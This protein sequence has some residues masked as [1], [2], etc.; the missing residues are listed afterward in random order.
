MTTERAAYSTLGLRA[1][2]GP[3]EVN[4]AYRRLMKKHHPDKPGGD[5]HR[6][7]EINRAYTLLRRRLG[8]PVW[9]P[10]PVP[11]RRRRLRWS[12]AAAAV[13]IVAVAVLAALA[14]QDARG[15]LARPGHLIASQIGLPTGADE[16]ALSREAS[17]F[18]DPVQQPLV[19]KAVATAVTFH[20]SRDLSGAS[21]YSSDCQKS[22]RRQPNVAWFDT[23]A[24]FDEA[25][26]TLATDEDGQGSG[27]FDESTV[28][29]REVA[30]ARL[31]SDDGLA[32]DSRL[33]EIRSEV[34]LKI[35]PLLDSAAAIQP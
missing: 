7:A 17:A 19:D 23:C 11:P 27:D 3:A 32:A 18:D 2:A 10:V 9:V 35:L 5:S 22:L 6:A 20:A 30:A 14:W 1:G 25:M 31:L 15:V 28:T 16:L 29:L 34:D 33:H 4:E 24:A 8:E 26:L 13:A 21:A 12:Q